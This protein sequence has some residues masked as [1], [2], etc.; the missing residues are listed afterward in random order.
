MTWDQQPL[1]ICFF[2]PSMQALRE[3]PEPFGNY[4][5]LS[6][7][8]YNVISINLNPLHAITVQL[9]FSFKYCS[10]IRIHLIYIL[11]L[12]R[13]YNFASTVYYHPGSAGGLWCQACLCQQGCDWA[14]KHNL[15]RPP[16]AS[17]VLRDDKRSNLI[18]IMFGC[19]ILWQRVY[20]CLINSCFIQLR[21]ICLSKKVK[22][23]LSNQYLFPPNKLMSTSS[24]R[25]GLG[26]NFNFTCNF[27]WCDGKKK[28]ISFNLQCF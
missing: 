27:T 3:F 1:L 23:G 24:H 12:T 25:R 16:S 22:A 17:L 6:N 26:P 11:V 20:R 8:E 7:E 5:W 28:R 14:G 19:R 18:T 2:F 21:E 10:Y 9:F 4:L 13:F 15:A